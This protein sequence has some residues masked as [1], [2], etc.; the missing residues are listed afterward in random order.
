MSGKGA[1]VP[2]SV[3]RV[4]KSEAHSLIGFVGTEV[5]GRTRGD[6]NVGAIEGLGVC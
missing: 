4:R 5:R 2:G 3:D 1:L 6:L